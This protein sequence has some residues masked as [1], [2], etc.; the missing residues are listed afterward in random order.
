MGLI[1][2]VN[3]AVGSGIGFMLLALAGYSVG[4]ENEAAAVLRLKVV[5]LGIPF[6]LV[7]LSTLLIL[8]WPLT[9][10]KQA[11]IRRRIETRARR[12]GK[13]STESY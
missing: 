9:R 12:A 4:G 10:E 3:G 6:L 1:S 11:S 13:L 7:G 5:V 2:K 8:K